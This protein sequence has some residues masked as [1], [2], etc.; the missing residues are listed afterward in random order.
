MLLRSYRKAD[1][2]QLVTLFF[3]TVHSVNAGDYSEAQLAVWAPEGLDA[4]AWCRPFQNDHTL[5]AELDGEIVGFANLGAGGHLDRLY[6]HKGH[7]RQGIATRLMAGVEAHAREQGHRA[8]SAEVSITAKPF[9][10]KRGYV[11]LRENTV[12]RG[13]QAL[14]N[15]KM[16]KAL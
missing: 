5:V 2:A 6:V 8:V 4:E 11:L 10:L 16:E 9:F 7:Q 15:Y 1:D 12:E 14:L 13:G 3:D